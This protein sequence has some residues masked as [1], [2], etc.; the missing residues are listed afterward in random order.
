MHK[1]IKLER[2]NSNDN[3][4]SG[5]LLDGTTNNQVQVLPGQIIQS[6]NG[7]QLFI[8]SAAQDASQ[9]IQYGSQNNQQL[10]LLQFSV[11]FFFKFFLNKFFY[12]NTNHSNI[13]LISSQHNH[14]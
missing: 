1:P 14:N 8:H 13:L 9:L 3:Q 6:V 5:V 4:L 2:F 11:S 7:Q 12:L 10:Q